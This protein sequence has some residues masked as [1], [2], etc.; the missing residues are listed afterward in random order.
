M[1]RLEKESRQAGLPPKPFQAGDSTKVEVFFFLDVVFHF[2]QVGND[3]D[4]KEMLR[5]LDRCKEVG[6]FIDCLQ[7]TYRLRSP[8]FYIA[9]CDPNTTRAIS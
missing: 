8:N 1:N 3:L 9:G 6:R 5:D 4:A 7:G 2:S